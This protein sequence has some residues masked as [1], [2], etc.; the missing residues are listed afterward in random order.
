LHFEEVAQ[1]DGIRR[2]GVEVT[3]P[4]RAFVESNERERVVLELVELVVVVGPVVPIAFV[5]VGS[6]LGL[7]GHDEKGLRLDSCTSEP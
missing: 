6:T 4:D 1:A 5:A 3:E 7:V 2:V